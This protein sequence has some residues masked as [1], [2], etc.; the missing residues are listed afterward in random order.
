METAVLIGKTIESY[1]CDN[2]I[3]LF[4]ELSKFTHKMF[5]KS[6]FC[7]SDCCILEF[8]IKAGM[9]VGLLTDVMC[10]VN[11]ISVESF[12]FGEYEYSKR[13]RHTGEKWSVPL[14]EQT[15]YVAFCFFFLKK[16]TLKR[17]LIFFY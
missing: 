14:S 5:V 12:L 2:T 16:E 15:Q 6:C 10:V 8:I 13:D 1:N 4:I 11:K 17:I 3:N 9:C 7:D